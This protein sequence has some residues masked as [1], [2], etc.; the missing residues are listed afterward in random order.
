MSNKYP[1]P[2]YPPP[3]HTDAG[4]YPPSQ[5]QQQQDYFGAPVPYQYNNGAPPNQVGYANQDRGYGGGPPQGYGYPPQQQGGYG[6]G[7]GYPPQGGGGG[8]Y[9]QQAGAPQGY[10]ADGR[11]GRSGAGEGICAAV[12]A[13]LACCCCLD[14]LI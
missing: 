9:Y 4:P 12:M 1:P 8:M 11:G 10:Y 2:A 14:F 6:Y 5:P 13:S 3:A 7:G